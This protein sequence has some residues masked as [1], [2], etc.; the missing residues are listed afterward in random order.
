M[1]PPATA[2]TVPLR[3]SSGPHHRGLAIRGSLLI[4]LGLAEAAMLL[5]AFRI[6]SITTAEMTM[7]LA[8]FLLADGAVALFEAGAAL[9]R[10]DSWVALVG[11]AV[12]SLGA[13]VLVVVAAAP[14]RFRPFAVWAIVTGVLEA[15]QARTPAGRTPGRLAAAII[16]VAFGLFALVGP[17]QDRA[18]LL[19]VAAA[20][21]VVAGG[22]RLSGALRSR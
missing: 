8:I 2:S 12:I 20:F 18:V 17:L 10:R 1:T 3:E 19:L 15:V 13:G 6:P 14:G 22:L 4:L 11:D 16:S 5:F 21:A 9:A 7:A